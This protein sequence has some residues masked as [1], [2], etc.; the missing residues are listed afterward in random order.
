MEDRNT[1]S[2]TGVKELYLSTFY[3]VPKANESV[4]LILLKRKI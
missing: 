2:L 3:N 1:Q 4:P